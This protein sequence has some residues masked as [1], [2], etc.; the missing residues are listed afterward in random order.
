M[1]KDLANIAHELDEEEVALD[2]EQK[3]SQNYD[4]T[5]YFSIQVCFF[6]IIHFSFYY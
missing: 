4:D 3:S 5:G 2:S 6:I 1:F